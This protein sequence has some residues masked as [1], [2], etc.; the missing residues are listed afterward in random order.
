M[1]AQIR[2]GVFLQFSWQFPGKGQRNMKR[3]LLLIL[4]LL[5]LI[6]VG[7]LLHVAT[8]AQQQAQRNGPTVMT[9]GTWKAHN[10]D[11]IYTVAVST[12]RQPYGPLVV[13]RASGADL[14]TSAP[15]IA[16]ARGQQLQTPL[17]FPS[18][19]GQYVA[20]LSPL[21][22]TLSGASLY[23]LSTAG[24]VNTLLVPD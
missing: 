12:P 23:L 5:L 4:S 15:V 20:L 22:N 11:L 24:Q 9:T 13:Y 10:Y 3:T 14:R 18:P 8:Y 16:L 6:P 7:L 19:N 1:A 21:Q 2:T 17:F